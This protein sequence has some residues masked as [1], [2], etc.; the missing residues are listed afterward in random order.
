MLLS[1]ATLGP[2]HALNLAADEVGPGANTGAYVMNPARGQPGALAGD[3]DTATR[4][5]AVQWQFVRVSTGATAIAD[6]GTA[7]EDFTVEYWYRATAANLGKCVLGTLNDEEKTFMQVE[8][9]RRGFNLAFRSERGHMMRVYMS[10]ANTAAM[11]DGHYHHAA[12][13]VTSASDGRAAVYVDGE[14]DAGAGIVGAAP[15]GF[16]RFQYDLAIGATHDRGDFTQWIDATL[17]EVVLYDHALAADRIRDHVRRASSGEPGAYVAAVMQDDPFAYWRLGEPSREGLRLLLDERIV[18]STAN[19]VLRVGRVAKHP[20][21]PLFG[22]EHPWEP[23][24]DNLYPNVIYDEVEQLYKAWY[25]TFTYDSAVASTPRD[26]RAPGAYMSLHPAR[27][28]GLGYAVSGDGIHWDKPMMEVSPWE[29][30]PSNLLVQPAHGVG[31][32]KDARERDPARRYKM[33]HKG[34]VMSVRF[35]PNGIRWGTNIPCPEMDAAGDTHNNALWVPELGKYVAFT[36]L[37]N[38]QRRVVGR[39]ESSDFIYW[40]RAEEVLRGERLFDVYSM[41]VF[42]HGGVYLG[43]PAIFDEV[44]DRVHVELAWSPDTVQWHRIEAGTPLIPNAPDK[45][46]YDWGTV[47]ASRPVVLDD[48]IQLY[49]GGCDGG[50][51]DWRDGFLCLA[52]LRPDGFAGYE[53]VDASQP[54]VVVTRPITGGKTLKITADAAGGTVIVSLLN[55]AGD[56]LA[57]ADAVTGEVTDRVVSWNGSDTVPKHLTGRPARLRFEVRNA[58]LYSFI[59]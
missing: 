30:R 27:Q 52:T 20:A 19:A 16:A 31:I 53:P 34:R 24:F 51:F 40:T 35:S 59:L 37:W 17:D 4:F 7:L 39:S 48:E 29:G 56:V 55:E 9:D 12:W 8:V 25:F 44:A 32:L 3:P 38:Q 36:R 6:F 21:N 15:G 43:L 18:A 57:T 42:A 11:R 23:R 50:H 54:A 10:P 5:D 58:K 33:I 14:R 28:D 1:L 45:G 22:Q 13:V 49:Y 46:A 47:Y 26:Q 41:P 2:A